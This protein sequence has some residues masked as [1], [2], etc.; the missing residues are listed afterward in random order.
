MADILRDFKNR[1]GVAIQLAKRLCVMSSSSSLAQASM[2][3]SYLVEL[4]QSCSYNGIYQT[5]GIII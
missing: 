1:S 5:P 4:K 2:N 3:A